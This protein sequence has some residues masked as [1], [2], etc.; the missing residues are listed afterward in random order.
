[1]YHG[2]A[3]VVMIAMCLPF[4][5]KLLGAMETYIDVTGAGTKGN[6]AFRCLSHCLHP[7][8]SFPCIDFVFLRQ[9]HMIMSSHIIV[10]VQKICCRSAW[11]QTADPNRSPPPARASTW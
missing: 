4:S 2:S 6:L 1:M 5:R 11:L 8:Q 10:H 9:V 3:A 7:H